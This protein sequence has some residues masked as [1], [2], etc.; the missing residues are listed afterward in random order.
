M[1]KKYSGSP[2][3]FVSV[4]QLRFRF[5]AILGDCENFLSMK[6]K[7]QASWRP[8]D[9]TENTLGPIHILFRGQLCKCVA[10]MINTKILTP[11]PKVL[12]II[13]TIA[14]PIPII[15]EKVE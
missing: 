7:K 11:I 5:C 8:C 1:T 10:E 12:E 3:K 6:M 14:V 4:P 9:A 15:V 2:T 13:Y